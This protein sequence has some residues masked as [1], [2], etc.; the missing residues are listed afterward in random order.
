MIV[1]G[2]TFYFFV[3]FVKKLNRLWMTGDCILDELLSKHVLYWAYF[4]VEVC[5]SEDDKR[6]FI[7]RIIF[8]NSYYM[9]LAYFRVTMCNSEGD[10][11]SLI[12]R[13]IFINSYYMYLAYLR[14]KVCTS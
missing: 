1:N 8:I 5:N 11:R 4:A 13:I 14:V 10:K 12:K 6:S 2:D 7:K 9:Y 3:Q